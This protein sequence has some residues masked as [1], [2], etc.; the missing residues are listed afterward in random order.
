M[1]T[2]I[3]PIQ[4][5]DVIRYRGRITWRDNF[6][7]NSYLFNDQLDAKE[8]ILSVLEFQQELER[9]WVSFES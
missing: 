5:G 4:D 1:K 2:T 3:Q 6:Q 9:R 7:F 8:W